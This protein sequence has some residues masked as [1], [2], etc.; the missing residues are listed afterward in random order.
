MIAVPGA[1]DVMLGYQSLEFEDIAYLQEITGVTPAPAF[2]AWLQA[3]GLSDG[4]RADTGAMAR[5]LGLSS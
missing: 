3:V 2:G 1:D 5:R 4:A